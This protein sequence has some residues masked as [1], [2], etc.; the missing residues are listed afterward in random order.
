M[1]QDTQFPDTVSAFNYACEALDCSIE[2]YR[3][4]PALVMNAAGMFNTAEGVKREDDGTQLAM[5]KVASADGG[6]FVLSK[7]SG[8][9]GPALQ[10]GEFVAWMPVEYSVDLAK[11]SEDERFGWVGMI[12]GTLDTKRESGSWVGLERFE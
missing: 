5:L 6:F 3:P 8:P 2:A 11:S 7:T 10:V 1:N 9:S 12:F 4:L